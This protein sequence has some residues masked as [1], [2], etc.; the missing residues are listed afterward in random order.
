MTRRY[1]DFWDMERE[2]AI[3]NLAAPM[4]DLNPLP[5]T[6]QT[7]PTPSSLTLEEMLRITATLLCP[8]GCLG[9]WSE[10]LL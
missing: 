5:Q 9:V 6:S 8:K 2:L 3:K 10:A 7:L 1:F 4:L